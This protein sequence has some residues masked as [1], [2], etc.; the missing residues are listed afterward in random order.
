MPEDLKTMLFLEVVNPPLQGVAT[1]YLKHALYLEL[2]SV[3]GETT[4]FIS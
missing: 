4:V 2:D 3:S 1:W